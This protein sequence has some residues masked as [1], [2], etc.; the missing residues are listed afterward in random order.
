VTE[1]I[2]VLVAIFPTAWLGL[3]SSDPNVL[4]TG[5]RYLRIV[6]PFY[7]AM[8]LGMLLYFASQG[9]GRVL[10][11]VLAGTLRLVIAALFGWLAVA[12]LGFGEPALFALVAAAAAAFG[13]V[14][15]ASMLLGAWGRG[16]T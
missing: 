9:A 15:A 2:G 16:T 12:W 1:A 8:G 10:W 4:A 11:P 3:F 6:G 7:G 5:A 13:A 14:N